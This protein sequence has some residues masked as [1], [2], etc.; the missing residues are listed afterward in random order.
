MTK[1]SFLGTVTPYKGLRVYLRSAM[2]MP[3][4][5]EHL[6]ELTARVFDDYLLFIMT[7]F[8]FVEILYPS[9][10]KTGPRYSTVCMK[11]ILNCHLLKLSSA[12]NKPQS[13]GGYGS[14]APYLHV[15]TRSL[16]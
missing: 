3:G 11:I 9:C 6:Q 12:Q 10:F 13:L 8:G 7:T 4:S 1:S 2:G 15:P 16:L 14:V 5:S